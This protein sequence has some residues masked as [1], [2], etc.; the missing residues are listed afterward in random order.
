MVHVLFLAIALAPPVVQEPAAA[1]APATRIVFET[2]PVADLFYS[3]RAWASP[4]APGEPGEPAPELAEAVRLVADLDRELERFFLAW[5]QI[6]GGLRG[7]QTA[8]DLERLFAEV[9]ESVTLPSGKAVRL[10]E[11]ALRIAAAL[12]EAEP[13]FLE[14][15]WP[16]HQGALADAR[17]LLQRDFEPHQAECLAFHLDRLA[18]AD[19]GLE[20][21][22][23]LVAEAPY[24]GAVTHRDA[25][26]RGV[27]YVAVRAT[28]GTQLFETV[29]HEATHSLDVATSGHHTDR[30]AHSGSAPPG[31]LEDLRGRLSRAG[32]SQR[33]RAYRDLPHTLMFVQSAASIRRTVAAEH[34][35]YGDVAGYYAKVPE[36]AALVR[37]AWGEY[38]AG[39]ISRDAALERIAAGAKR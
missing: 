26:G 34:E 19:P 27:S 39:T 23:V 1:A 9:P 20:L 2:S 4:G 6:E 16:E 13:W 36:A 30:S 21:P 5:G 10:R 11:G 7:A 22:V 3:V 35:D 33:D 28:E 15:L 8:A 29:L 31:A 37:A 25:E 18:M 12:R 17:D 38:L 32:F 24:P 14:H